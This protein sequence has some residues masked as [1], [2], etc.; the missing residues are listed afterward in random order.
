MLELLAAAVLLAASSA[1]AE[2]PLK[3]AKL[4]PNFVVYGDGLHAAYTGATSMAVWDLKELRQISLTEFEGIDKREEPNDQAWGRL[5][6][7]AVSADGKTSL[8]AVNTSYR[9]GP[10]RDDAVHT[11]KVAVNLVSEGR[12]RKIFEHGPGKCN[13]LTGITV[14]CPEA[15]H[16]I[17]S[18]D[19]SKIL[20][21][22]NSDL[23]GRP[24]SG[25]K[26]TPYGWDANEARVRIN[27]VLAE[28][29]GKVLERR[30]YNGLYE[31]KNSS[32]GWRYTPAE[33]GAGFLRDG[34]PV[35]ISMDDAGCVVKEFS[36]KQVSFLDDCRAD[37]GPYF[38]DGLVAASKGPFTAWDPATGA[39]ITKSP[40]VVGA[41]SGVISSDD[42]TAIAEVTPSSDGAAASVR[43]TDAASGKVVL[44]R[45]VE[46]PG[47]KHT[48][49][50]AWYSRANGRLSVGWYGD[51]GH[52]FAIYD[53]GAAAAV[54]AAPA[55]PVAPAKP[56]LDLDS[57]PAATTPLDPEAFAIVVGVEKYRQ[58]GLPSVDYAARDA[59]AMRDYLVGAMG[60]DPKNVLLL[61]ND[62]ASKTDLEK[63]FGKWLTNRATAKSRVFVYY[64]GHGAP[65][66]ATGEAYLMP[67]EADPAY[68]EDTAYPAARLY[69]ALAKLPTK[70]ATVVLDACFS[71]QGGRSLIAKGT[72]P[73]VAV[74]DQSAGGSVIV[75]AAAGGAQI[76]ASDPERRHGLLT[77]SLLEGLHGAADADGDGKI[78]AAELFAFARPAVERA[79][80]LQNVEQ[81]PTVSPSAEAL[82]G[83]LPWVTLKR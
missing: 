26:R 18:P 10:N 62:R 4:L 72:R 31:S 52:Q 50:S 55:P 45:V 34:R 57:P 15:Y 38:K 42:L 33:L 9:K 41:N 76:S 73:L 53:L 27:I 47:P 14:K 74:R 79:A 30:S 59:Q 56:A 21:W 6:P 82:R 63:A 25:A 35:L 29:T 43:V 8:V 64:A 69:A 81:T 23:D 17:I 20:L 11:G 13:S 44:S 5:Y 83:G 22:H 51:K 67:Y 75:L 80:R 32:W 24:A 49:S 46:M 19:G 60:F 61:V 40:I 1:R 16:A 70:R 68:L 54:A 36:G 71:G 78:T 3:A 65:N 28:I 7:L 48:V 66:P 37:R 12:V 2:A 77:A 39:V 58:E